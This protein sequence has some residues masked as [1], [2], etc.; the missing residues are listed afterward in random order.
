MAVVQHS[1]RI[2]LAVARSAVLLLAVAL[3]ACS[4]PNRTAPILDRSAGS[5]NS[6]QAREMLPRREATSTQAL[7]ATPNGEQHVVRKGDTLYSIAMEHGKDPRELA[8]WNQITDP[9]SLRI[10]QIISLA[11]QAG[12][13]APSQ[14]PVVAGVQVMPITSTGSLETQVLGAT[15]AA[16]PA[17]TLAKP[18][19]PRTELPKPLDEI[20]WAWPVPGKVVDTFDSTRNKGIDM[21]G[22]VGDP[23]QAA[24][25]GKVVYSGNGLRGYGNLV[26]VKHSESFLSAYAHNSK[27]LV[28]QGDVV[29]RGQKIAELG[30]SDSDK[31]KLH[32]EIRRD[33]QPVDP[34]KFL[35][36]R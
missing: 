29:K 20:N 6:S 25:D 1:T 10:G 9:A 32:F 5:G 19:S 8:Q 15:A 21:S 28:N 27:L 14:E 31:P 12:V 2:A 17:P 3:V 18:E 30:I 24:S 26:I 34:L 11:P 36:A 4:S 22:K 33:G 7:P 35:P 23:V 13:A 16:T